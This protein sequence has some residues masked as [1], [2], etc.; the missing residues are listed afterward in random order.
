MEYCQRPFHATT[1]P[2]HLL[3][4]FATAGFQTCVFCCS[5]FADFVCVCVWF[6][7]AGDFGLVKL[8]LG[9]YYITN[10]SGSGTVTHLAPELF[11][12]RARHARLN[13]C[14]CQHSRSAYA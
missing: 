6:V 2:A 12:V 14:A 3:V 8:L 7:P 13:L 9:K 5:G 11:E 1:A 10:R 4:C